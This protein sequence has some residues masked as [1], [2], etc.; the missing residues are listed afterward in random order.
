MDS[1]FP[2][3]LKW[4][5]VITGVLALVALAAPDLVIIGLF[6]LLLPGLIL[7]A[8]PTAFLWGCI[9]ALFW[10]AIRT[11]VDKKTATLLAFPATALLLWGIPQPSRIIA[12]NNIERYK[13]ENITPEKPVRVVGNVRIDSESPG[14]D[15]K[16]EKLLGFRP[17]AC[18]NRC[19]ALLFEPGVTS[20][21][22]N[23]VDDISFDQLRS[24]AS[25]LD[26][27]ARTYRL[28]PKAQCGADALIPDLE[29]NIGYFGK[30][31]ED[32]RAF[33]AD[34]AAR[35]TS[36]VCL[37]GS[38]PLK[39]YDMLLRSGDWRSE[40]DVSHRDQSWSLGSRVLT[41]DYAEIRN[42]KGDILFRSF[43]PGTSALAVPFFI[44][45]DGGGRSSFEW[46]RTSI[47]KRS[48]EGGYPD[49]K[50]EDILDVSR[51]VDMAR[52]L[53]NV[54]Q[55]MKQTLADS[56]QPADNPAFNTIE[57][58]LHL[59]EKSSATEDDASIIAAL[60]ADPRLDD[61][62]G[63]WEL[64][65]IFSATQ[66]EALRPAIV[67]KLLSVPA[68]RQIEPTRL[69]AAFYD[70]PEG[71]FAKTD[72]DTLALLSDPA[73]R[74]RATGLIARQSD[75]GAASVPLLINILTYHVDA[76][77]QFDNDNPALSQ[78]EKYNGFAAHGNVIN[79]VLNGLCRLGPKAGSAL[80]TLMTLEN[81]GRLKR[82]DREVISRREWDRT[83]ARLGKP[84]ASFRKP[85]DL[86]GDD[87]SYRRN[88]A[89]YLGSFDAKHSCDR[90]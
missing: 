43:A 63:A 1:V 19:V 90:I 33:S 47:P 52:L 78:A 20:V 79:A 48:Y 83:L 85:K 70:W 15:N 36:D 66:L 75:Q 39:T 17:F 18:D 26:K 81:S 2:K 8:S 49:K 3:F 29:G 7:G 54:R 34:W 77:R 58:Y 32:N 42:R 44:N 84:V 65:K 22:I 31:M 87:E 68:D 71:A 50:L 55:T 88:I 12:N 67:R 16:N 57:S 30:T 86:S 10:V 5:L 23:K 27:L 28:Q 24:G 69:G 60:I 14:W 76:R 40:P 13:L 64:P 35:L 72:P 11:F 82:D 38:A 80:P 61:L 89:N 46:G 6:L 59:L 74:R 73:K 62:D 41:G 53:Q 25:P 9:Y 56:I 37:V 21:T 45:F 4:Y 51:T